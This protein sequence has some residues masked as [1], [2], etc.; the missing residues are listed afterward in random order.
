MD[1]SQT[2]Q[3]VG[4]M[5]LIAVGA[6]DYVVDGQSLSIRVGSKRGKL[7]RVIVTLGQDDTYSVRYV[8][9]R[10]RGFVPLD[11]ETVTQVHV[12]QIGV[13]VRKMGDRA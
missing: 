11:D 6:R 3:Q 8:S 7:E 13:V 9:Y 2:I 12:D 5:N 10:A 1:F 4:Q